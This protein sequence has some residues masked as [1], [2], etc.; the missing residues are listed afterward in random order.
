MF[1][2]DEHIA[3]FIQ[4]SGEFVDQL[5]PKILEAYE[6]KIIQLRS[7]KLP[8]GLV[9]LKNIFDCDDETNDKRNFVAIKDDYADLQVRDGRK[10]EVRKDV[11]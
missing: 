8:K 11:A 3:S 7:N 2:S 6:G 4:Y 5:Q 9:T 1:K 10:L